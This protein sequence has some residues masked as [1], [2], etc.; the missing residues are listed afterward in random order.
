MPIS[1]SYKNN[2][3]TQ[4]QVLGH[5]ERA[6]DQFIPPLSAK[7]ELNGY[8]QKIAGNAETIEAWDND[9]LIGLI[10]M[11]ANNPEFGGF[12]TNVS[13]EKEYMRRGLAAALMAESKKLVAHKGMNQITLEVARANKRA[14]DFYRKMDFTLQKEG[15]DS[16]WMIWKSESSQ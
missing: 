4:Q 3:A 8:A 2:S 11:Y 16:I 6:N 15:E 5:L 12:I 7:V 9:R 13:I 10:A 14:I 1:I